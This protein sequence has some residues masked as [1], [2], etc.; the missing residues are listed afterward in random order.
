MGICDHKKKLRYF[1]VKHYGRTHDSVCFNTSQLRAQL[2]AN[3][4][5]R[6]ARYLV[7]DEGV[8]NQKV[9]IT[10]FRRDRVITPAQKLY[11]RTLKRFRVHIEHTFGYLYKMSH[12]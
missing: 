2:E 3:F 8:P 4:N 6:K 5:P 1:S 10:A 7:S 9:L 12:L 11:N